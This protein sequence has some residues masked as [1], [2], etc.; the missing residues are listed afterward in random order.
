MGQLLSLL[1][2]TQGPSAPEDTAVEQQVTLTGYNV[3]DVCVR[4]AVHGGHVSVC[5]VHVCDCVC[6][7]LE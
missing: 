1:R 2:G 7:W 4:S 6:V 3:C 5:T